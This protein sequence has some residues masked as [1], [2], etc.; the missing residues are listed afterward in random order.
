VTHQRGITPEAPVSSQTAKLLFEVVIGRPRQGRSLS[1][2][3][4]KP[5]RESIY[6]SL[7]GF[8]M[9]RRAR[10]PAAVTAVLRPDLLPRRPVRAARSHPPREVGERH[11]RPCFIAAPA[12]SVELTWAGPLEIPRAAIP[13]CGLPADSRAFR[14][15]IQR[16]AAAPAAPATGESGQYPP[17]S[18]ESLPPLRKAIPR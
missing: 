1:D 6:D 9:F 15:P 2:T 8:Y 10:G 13:A 4:Y 5:L 18:R 17:A 14:P 16:P 11:H 12:A 3:T 7:A